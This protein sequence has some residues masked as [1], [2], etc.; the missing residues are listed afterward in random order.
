M[1]ATQ[2]NNEVEA[3]QVR[4]KNN[5]DNNI[6]VIAER[7]GVTVKEAKL[8]RIDLFIEKFATNNTEI[9][10]AENYRKKILSEINQVK[11]NL[12]FI[13]S[14]QF[15]ENLKKWEVYDKGVYVGY[16]TTGNKGTADHAQIN[17]LSDRAI[18]I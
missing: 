17:F 2:L 14:G 16:T 15:S 4:V 8:K 12:E 18:N 13:E 9:E 6:E 1:N 11:E 10:A 5:I 3:I 7:M